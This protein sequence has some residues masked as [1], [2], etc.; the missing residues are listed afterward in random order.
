[1][2]R[3]TDP[4]FRYVPSV[5]TDIR[6]TFARIRKELA[7]AERERADQETHL[8]YFEERRNAATKKT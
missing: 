1:M 8:I 5:E 6:K 4:D 7:K 2:K 3:I